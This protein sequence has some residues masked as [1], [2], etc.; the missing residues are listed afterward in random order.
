MQAGFSMLSARWCWVACLGLAFVGCKRNERITSGPLPPFEPAVLAERQGVEVLQPRQIEKPASL[1]VAVVDSTKDCGSFS[2]L[3]EAFVICIAPTSAGM[4]LSERVRG[5]LKELVSVRPA[6]LRRGP[7]TVI[8]GPKQTETVFQLV[9]EEPSFFAGL[10]LRNVDPVRVSNARV[11]GFGQNGGRKIALVGVDPGEVARVRS[12]G[13]PVAVRVE[14]F[15]DSVDGL[16]LALQY[17][18]VDEPLVVP[19]ATSP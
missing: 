17:A 2:G 10:V 9:G 6:Y 3:S 16:K 8:G 18:T 12:A 5:T 4:S 14:A 15:P 7:V 1:Q 19:E 11:F 13:L